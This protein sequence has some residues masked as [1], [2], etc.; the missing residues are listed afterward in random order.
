M[1]VFILIGMILEIWAVMF[2][3][4]GAFHEKQL[5]AAEKKI[6]RWFRK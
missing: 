3:V 5:I 1:S 6:A 4:W 2:L